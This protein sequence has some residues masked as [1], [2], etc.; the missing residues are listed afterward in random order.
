M[1][2][3]QTID[4]KKFENLLNE[5][6]YYT[7]NYYND[8]N[9]GI[10]HV[11]KW[12]LQFKQFGMRPSEMN[13]FL[14]ELSF[15]LK[16]Y[17]LTKQET[18]KQIYTFAAKVIK[19]YHTDETTFSFV[20]LNRHGHSQEDL[21]ELVN[22]YL[23]KFPKI[24]TENKSNNI[25]TF[26]YFDECIFTSYTAY[27]DV[28][29]WIK[30]LPK[31]ATLIFVFIYGYSSG[32]IYLQ[33]RINK[34]ILENNISIN[35]EYQVLIKVLNNDSSTSNQ[36]RFFPK[37]KPEYL[38]NETIKNYITKMMFVF[39]RHPKIFRYH[40]I[41]TETFFNNPTS[42]NIVEHYLLTAGLYIHGLADKN[43]SSIRPMGYEKLGG[44]GFGAFMITYRNISNNCPLAFWWGDEEIKDGPLSH[45]YPLFKRKTHNYSF[46]NNQ[47]NIVK[48]NFNWSFLNEG[49]EK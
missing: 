39:P 46:P 19:K 7:I 22:M 33:N 23:N 2:I 4:I 6:S 3:E 14:E 15:L 11:R 36:E 10:E 29:D 38:S 48:N 1:S 9:K 34:F 27:Y 30:T 13:I 47:Q 21:L 8:E 17:Y 42:R 43:D 45:W 16:K 28:I 25:N 5:I 41:E 24:Q 37:Y 18:W 44:I 35:I 40:D 31:N 12:I 49:G 20:Q 26:I 32:I